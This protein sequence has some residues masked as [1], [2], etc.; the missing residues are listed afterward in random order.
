M[1]YRIFPV[2]AK[3]TIVTFP[4]QCPPDSACFVVVIYVQ[5]LAGFGGL[6]TD[7]AGAPLSLD[8]QLV[9]TLSQPVCPL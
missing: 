8:H 5:V 9:L 4:A 1:K 6:I 7:K 3:Q 2:S